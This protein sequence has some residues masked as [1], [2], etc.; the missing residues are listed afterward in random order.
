MD[1]IIIMHGGGKE[2]DK[3]RRIVRFLFFGN[4]Q[5]KCRK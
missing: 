5:A 2:K 1:G 3:K 4:P